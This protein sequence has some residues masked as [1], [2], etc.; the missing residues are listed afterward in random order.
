MKPMLES[1]ITLGEYVDEQD[2]K[3]VCTGY[4]V[5]N[6]DGEEFKISREMYQLLLHADGRHPFKLDGVSPTKM[7]RIQS[8]MVRC[9]I[10]RTSRFA[11]NG[12][13]NQFTLLP[14]G[15]RSKRAK[16]RF[17]SVNRMLP[18]LT[19]LWFAIGVCTTYCVAV[20]ENWDSDFSIPILVLL[21]LAKCV[22][23]Y[24]LKKSKKKLEI[25]T[26]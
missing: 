11:R 3:E 9:K 5:G 20:N 8:E 6:R 12:L 23:I 26:K 22:S 2:G 17:A 18:W 13:I 24:Y 14:I 19:L 4:Y 7:R 21:M 15:E 16:H 25:S 1:G 10:I